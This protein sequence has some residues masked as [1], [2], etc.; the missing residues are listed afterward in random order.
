[1]TTVYAP[2]YTGKREVHA[3]MVRKVRVACEGRLVFVNGQHYNLL[4]A[5]E[6]EAWNFWNRSGTCKP[7][8]ADD[9]LRLV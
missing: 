6:A 1:M 5:T 2:V 9:L 3:I 4:Y 8:T 7:L